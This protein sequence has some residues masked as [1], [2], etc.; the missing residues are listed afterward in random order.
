[1]A[2]LIALT[3]VVIAGP[4]KSQFIVVMLD[5]YV[6][7]VILRVTRIGAWLRLAVVPVSSHVVLH[8]HDTL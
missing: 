7:V 6:S 8:P 3:T 5:G 4:S 1:M 2:A